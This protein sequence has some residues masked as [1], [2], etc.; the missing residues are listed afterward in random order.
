MDC[1][2]QERT[3]LGVDI[4]GT[5]VCLALVTEKGELLH[6]VS[7]PG[8]YGNQEG[9]AGTLF[10]FIDSLL[11]ECSGQKPIGIGVGI[12]ALVDIEQQKV[13]SSS[14]LNVLVHYDLCGE[15]YKRYKIKAVIENDVNAAAMAETRFGAG[16]YINDFAYI[17]IGTGT[18]A[19]IIVGGKLL[20]G[21]NN[22]AGELGTTIYERDCEDA[23]LFTLESV[24]SGRGIEDEVRRLAHKYPQ[25]ALQKQLQSGENVSAALHVFELYRKGD[26]L[27]QAVMSNALRVMGLGIYNLEKITNSHLYIFG[28]GVVSDWFLDQLQKE[29]D[30]LCEKMGVIWNARFL[31]SELGVDDVG[32]LGAASILLDALEQNNTN[33]ET[34]E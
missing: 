25:S 24:A 11:K 27:A 14:I 16:R 12:K 28:G 32:V 21:K 17:N 4:G 1:Q 30:Y 29:I 2:K 15:L 20:R 26:A 34:H 31:I 8:N 7:Y 10:G 5:K 23:P 9:F 33:H 13:Y 6:K 22:H 18:A 19:G 3:V